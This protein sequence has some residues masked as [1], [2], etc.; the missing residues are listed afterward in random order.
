MDMIEENRWRFNQFRLHCLI[1]HLPSERHGASDRSLSFSM[2]HLCL[3]LEFWVFAWN[4]NI[5]HRDRH[6]VVSAAS[7][8]VTLIIRVISAWFRSL[9]S[10]DVTVFSQQLWFCQLIMWDLTALAHIIEMRAEFSRVYS[11]FQ[12]DENKRLPGKLKYLL[13]LIASLV[14]KGYASWLFS[15]KS[16]SK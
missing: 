12:Y 6:S 5:Y 2:P 9:V 8:N 1:R 4:I 10:A 3:P 16:K 7:L 13:N 11:S 14:W 15:L